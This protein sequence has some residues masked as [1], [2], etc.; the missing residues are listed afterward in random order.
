MAVWK[1]AILTVDKLVSAVAEQIDDPEVLVGISSWHIYPDIAFLRLETTVVE[2][3]DQLVQKGGL[4][5]VGMQ[6]SNPSKHKGIPWTMPL[7]QLQ[8]C[9][10][11]TKVR[12]IGEDSIRVS[13]GNLVH[14]AMGS[15]I[16]SWKQDADDFDSVCNFFIALWKSLK[17]SNLSRSAS[18]GWHELFSQ[19]GAAYL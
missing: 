9:K 3:N 15:V 13:F 5:T 11:E 4:I 10:P 2:Q 14:V 19:Q 1:K 7:A 17:R 16:S 18:F 6:N 8:Y 12:S